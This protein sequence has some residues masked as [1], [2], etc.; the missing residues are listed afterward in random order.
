VFDT[1]VY[2]SIIKCN[3]KDTQAKYTC[4]R[5]ILLSERKSRGPIKMSKEL[6]DEE[7]ETYSRQIVLSDIGYDGQ[8]KLRNGI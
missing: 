8:L 7:L 5:L 3:K 2:E 1:S 6:T 4:L